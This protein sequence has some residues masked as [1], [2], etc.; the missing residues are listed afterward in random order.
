MTIE[1]N[2]TNVIDLRYSKLISTDGAYEHPLDIFHT[3][4]NMQHILQYPTLLKLDKWS[5]HNIWILRLNRYI[6]ICI[7][8]KLNVTNKFVVKND[9][10]TALQFLMSLYRVYLYSTFWNLS[11]QLTRKSLF[12]LLLSIIKIQV[13]DF[14]AFVQNLVNC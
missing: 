8:V 5:H 3:L 11:H 7:R 13:L 4:H 6:H 2:E 14:L 10:R 1:D 12:S 9:I